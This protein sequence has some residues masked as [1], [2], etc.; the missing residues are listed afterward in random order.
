MPQ[1]RNGG[2]E[3]H[4]WATYNG[5]SYISEIGIPTHAAGRTIDLAFSNIPFATAE[6]DLRLQTG[7]DHETIRISI[8]RY[9]Q[10]S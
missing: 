3:I 1:T 5:L 7:A 8:A 9:D 2:I 10:T 4:D 6:V